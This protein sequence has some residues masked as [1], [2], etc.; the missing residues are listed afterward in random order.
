MKN[1]F[2]LAF[3]TLCVGLLN[4]S[5][6]AQSIDKRETRQTRR[7]KG[8]ILTSDSLP[9]VRI[10]FDKSFKFKGSQKF[11]LYDR[12]EAEQFY[13]VDADKQ[14]GTLKNVAYLAPA[15]TQ[16]GRSW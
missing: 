9:P 11:T 7:V 13:F 5:V 12:A 4:T 1:L 2:L 16:S 6:C 10:K 15:Q 14:Q 8:R 3:M